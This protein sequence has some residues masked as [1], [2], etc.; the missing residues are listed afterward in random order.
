MSLFRPLIPLLCTVL[1]TSGCAVNPVTGK[2]ELSLLSTQQEVQIGQQQYRPQLQSQGGR[3][4]VDN[5]LQFYI[6]QVGQRLAKVSDRPDLPYEFTVLNSSVPNAWALPGG[7]IAINRGL[8]SYMEDEAQLAAVLAHEIVHAAARHTAAR[9]SQQQLLNAGL[10]I[11]GGLAQDTQYSGALAQWG[12]LGASALLARYGRDDELESDEYGMLY[13][14]RAGYDPQGAVELQQLFVRLSQGSRNDPIS[15][16]FASHP[17]SQQR[18]AANKQHVARLGAGG[19]RHRSRY[20]RAIAQLKKDAPAYKAA[21]EAQA[22]LQQKKPREALQKLDRAVALQPA[23]SEFW[24]LRG[25]AWEMQNN[26]GNAA[27]SYTTAIGKNPAYFKPHVMR[28]LVRL[29]QNEHAAAEKDLLASYRILP[30]QVASFYLGE[31]AYQRRNYP[32]AQKYFQE[33]ARG[34]GD[35]AQKAQQRIAEMQ[36]PSEQQSQP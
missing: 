22:L 12:G 15:A 3:Y 32:V 16:L 14:K 20:Q 26:L 4:Y 30:T 34:S 11:A 24:E 36:P 25:I 2:K 8:L 17:P 18:V 35:L 9:L 28:G 21:Q 31:F 1:L 10:A 7:K 6:N 33:A 29:Q 13:M 27:K 19:E 23:E 5:E